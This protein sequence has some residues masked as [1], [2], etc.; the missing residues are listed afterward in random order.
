MKKTLVVIFLALLSFSYIFFNRISADTVSYPFDSITIVEAF[1]FDVTVP[2]T[3]TEDSLFYGLV[4]E[5]DI[6]SIY[7]GTLVFVLDGVEVQGSSRVIIVSDNGGNDLFQFLI[8]GYSYQEGISEAFGF[9]SHILIDPEVGVYK[10]LT[11]LDAGIQ[12]LSVIHDLQSDTWSFL[13]NDGIEMPVVPDT[14]A[15][16]SGLSIIISAYEEVDE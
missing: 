8:N 12:E 5:N 13:D 16:E 7:V 6:L 10:D 11:L 4:E 9:A 15:S 2:N 14:Y 3:I 1:T